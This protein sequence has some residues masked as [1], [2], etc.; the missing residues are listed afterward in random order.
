METI[1][2]LNSSF[3]SIV[4]RIHNTGQTKS[5]NLGIAERVMTRDNTDSNKSFSDLQNIF[6]EKLVNTGLNTFISIFLM[7]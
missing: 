1:T 5:N 2:F 3:A 4:G 6:K 7:Y